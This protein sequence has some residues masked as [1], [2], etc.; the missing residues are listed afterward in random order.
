M[1]T[2]LLASLVMV[3]CLCVLLLGESS[4][5]GL[6]QHGE[7]VKFDKGAWVSINSDTELIQ[8]GKTVVVAVHGALSDPQAAFGACAARLADIQKNNTTLLAFQYDSSV[9]PVFSANAMA[10]E[11]NRLGTRNQHVKFNIVAHSMGTLVVAGAILDQ[12]LDLSKVGRFFAIAGMPL[13]TPIVDTWLLNSPWFIELYFGIRQIGMQRLNY[14]E[15]HLKGRTNHT[16]E[17]RA[18]GG[19]DDYV[20]PRNAVQGWKTYFPKAT[21]VEQKYDS[22][23]RFQCEDS[24]LKDIEKFLIPSS[25]PS[26]PAVPGG[27]TVR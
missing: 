11:L 12:G 23:H 2:R 4:A 6:T 27:L 22:P 24:V 25:S 14:I 26:F 20:V 16:I 9:E 7:L 13:G 3:G 8:E 18:Y 19:T 1:L 5:G 10:L 15:V 17:V 21:I